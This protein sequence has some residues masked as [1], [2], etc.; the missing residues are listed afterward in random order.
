MIEFPQHVVGKVF[1]TTEGVE[2]LTVEMIISEDD[3]DERRKAS[4][5]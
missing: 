3:G 1:E 5:Y 2:K 4:V